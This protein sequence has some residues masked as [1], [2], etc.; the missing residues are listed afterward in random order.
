MKMGGK[1]LKKNTT[2]GFFVA[3]DGP[4]GVGKTTLLEEIEKIIKSKNIQ[5]YKTKE[6]TNSILGNFIRE[7]SEEINGDTLACLV[8]ADR[9]EHLKNEII[10]ELEKGKIVITDRY[11]LSSLILQV[12]D[13]V[14]ENFILNLNSQ[15]IKPDLQ[16]AIFA[17]EKVIQERLDQRETLTRFEKNNQSKKEINNMKKGIEKLRKLNIEV[18][19]INNN[20]DLEYNAN[21]IAD[22][23]IENWRKK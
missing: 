8:S 18:L 9:Y 16:L 22:Y 12:I 17:D 2:K 23:I 20:N 21:K 11:V 14:K 1:N 4:N 5:L 7:I 19:C 15:I 3:I 10:P 6:P 13:G